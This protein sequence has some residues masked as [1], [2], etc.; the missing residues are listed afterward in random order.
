MKADKLDKNV[1]EKEI[2]YNEVI[3][4]NEMEDYTLRKKK[5]IIKNFISKSK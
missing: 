2:S 3:S 4:I 1:Y 5:I